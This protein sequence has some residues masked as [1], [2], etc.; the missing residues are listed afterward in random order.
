MDL[1]KS[2][3]CVA[4]FLA[5]VIVQEGRVGSDLKKAGGGE[6][7]RGEEEGRGRGKVEK[8]GEGEAKGAGG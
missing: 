1:L 6:D 4:T 8:G 2:Y 3:I 5:F 7:T